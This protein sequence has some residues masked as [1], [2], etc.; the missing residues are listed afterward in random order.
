MNDMSP[1]NAARKLKINVADRVS[2]IPS[3]NSQLNALSFFSGALGLDMGLR[4]AGIN[5][6]LAC[7]IDRMCRQTITAND[8]QIGLI[9]DISAYSTDEIL[10]FSGLKRG[11]VDL[12]VGGPPC[13][14]FSTAGRRKGFEDDRGNVFL[15]YL[16]VILDLQP[17]YAVIENVR[18][19]LSAPLSHRPHAERTKESPLTADE[20][21]GGAMRHVIERLEAGGYGVSF[22]LYSSANYGVP[23]VR[24]RVVMICH[25][26]GDVLPW[27]MPTHSNVEAFGLPRWRTVEDA[28]GDLPEQTDH[29]EFPEERLR[30]YRMLK[31]G[32]YWKHLPPDMQKI[33]MGNSFFSGG[34]K[35]GFFRRLSWD[36]PS[37]T[38]VTHPAMPATDICH[39]VAD[40]PLS[41]NEY[42]RIQQFPDSWSFAGGL[43][44]Q[45]RQ[46]GNAVP[47]GLGHAIGAAL[48]A[49][50][51]GIKQEPPA[52]FPFSRYRGADHI[53]VKGSYQTTA[54]KQLALL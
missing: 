35:T 50:S 39:P 15:R 34:G 46:I 45:Y 19:L 33:A 1:I 26:G 20:L 31:E 2:R 7:E 52:D 17:E 43:V 47:V 41:V 54:S 37:C 25:R 28:I 23:Q 13:Q 48:V 18:G 3:S 4:S 51:N 27:M 36:K 30:Y 49:H 21:P 29:L 8:E 53:S 24:E 16:D 14:A 5:V 38:L 9:G 40:R 44:D 22:N 42:K 32:Q 10:K 11:Q 6:V 12:I